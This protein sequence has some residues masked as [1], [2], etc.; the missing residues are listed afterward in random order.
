VLVKNDPAYVK[1]LDAI[2]NVDFEL[3]KAWRLGSWDVFAG[4]AFREWQ[5]D[6]HVLDGVHN[7]MEYSLDVCEK[8]ITFDWGYRDKAA[9]HWLALTPADRYGIRRVYVYREIIRTE[10][11]PKDW[12]KLIKRFTDVEP[13]KFMVLPHDCFAH[14]E[15]KT[16][17]ASIFS[18]NIGIN[19][20]R[21]D[22]LAQG[23]RLNRKAILHDYLAEAPDGRP[24]LFVHPA[25]QDL[26][27]TLPEL[28]YDEKH[29]ED[30]D[31]TGDDHSYDS[32][33]LGLVSIGYRPDHTKTILTK[34][35]AIET[36]P[37]WQTNQYGNIPAPNF[38]QE[39]DRRRKIIP[40]DEEYR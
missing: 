29:V 16:T 28:Q 37:T 21:G 26:I 32:V 18:R 30:I 20:R 4:Q 35:R 2:K 7:K 33:T 36:F 24:Y 13:V 31:T 6:K 14:K 25:C 23:A 15:S 1:R 11:E 5:Y 39:M 12:A 40:H 34:P 10:T 9:A 17:I 19:I 27:T 38:W 3:Y 22:T 8:I